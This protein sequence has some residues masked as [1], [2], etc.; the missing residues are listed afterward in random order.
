MMNRYLWLGWLCAGC[1]AADKVDFSYAFAPPHRITVAGPSA[2]NKTLLDLEP[3]SLTAHWTYDDLRGLPLGI[4]KSPRLQWHVRMR[5]LVDGQPFASS[6][7]TRGE[8]F[9]PMLDNLYEQQGA[10]VRMEVIGGAKADVI[11]VTVRNADTR[12]HKVA[13]ECEVRSGW[14]AHNP[15][16]IEPGVDP[17]T[18]LACQSDRA[19]RVL[20]FSTGAADYP[21][22]RMKT[23]PS[24]TLAAGETRT[25]WIVRP[26]ETYQED[27]AALR[28]RDWAGEFAAAVGVWRELLARAV[29]VEELPVQHLLHP[30]REAE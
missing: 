30:R 24:W 11:R 28:R 1:F 22:E 6:K 26:Y 16:W 13:V 25:G 10:S 19:D 18:L 20:M 8:R 9:L 23:V 2:S 3:G 4:F 14:V 27:L 15:S 17:D 21:T 12:P 29:R 5:P 7:W